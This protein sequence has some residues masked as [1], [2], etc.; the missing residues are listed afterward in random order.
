MIGH[1]SPMVAIGGSWVTPTR[2]F[3]RGA[4]KLGWIRQRPEMLV[5]VALLAVFNFPVLFGRSWSSMMFQSDA[6][7][8]GEWW[9]L[10]THVFV[11]VTWYHLLLDAT[12]FL[13]LYS[14][15]M[16]KGLIRR[17]ACVVASAAGSL[18]LSFVFTN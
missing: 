7:A 12:A 10:F 16:E 18:G 6:V 15:L 11:H 5:F 4:Q 3:K 17:L 8:R 2:F 9:R 1:T 13:T 14:S